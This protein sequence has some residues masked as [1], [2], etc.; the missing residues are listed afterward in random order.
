MGRKNV[1]LFLHEEI[2]LLA[3]RDREG[4]VEFGSNY[5]YALSGAILAELL[6]GKR[7]EVE[8]TKRKLVNLVSA[9]P[10]GEAVL[11]ECLEKVR[12]AKRRANAQA[13]VNSFLQVKKLHHRIADSLC[14]RGI[15]RADEGTVLLLFKR[16]VYPE[17]DPLPERKLITRLRNAIFGDSRTVDPRTVV[18]ISLADS[19]GLLA[20][21]FDKKQLKAR[22]QRIK[23]ITDGELMGKAAREAIEAAQAAAVM[24][25]CI[26]PAITAATVSG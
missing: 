21:P 23:Q 4:T 10:M 26:T 9:E 5:G 11:D 18:L 2:M 22:K 1:P 24:V 14:E 16:K 13:W 17:I 7:I 8:E 25:A 6:M 20:I 19:A 12:N 15:L 3:L